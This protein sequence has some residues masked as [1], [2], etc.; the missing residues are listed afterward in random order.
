[1]GA[2]CSG[3][4]LLLWR[5]PLQ[6]HLANFNRALSG[7]LLQWHLANLE[8]GCGAPLEEVSLRYWDQDDVW[9]FAGPH[10]V[11]PGTTALLAALLLLYLLLYYCFTCFFTTGGYERIVQGLSEGLDIRLNSPVTRV[12]CCFTTAASLQLLYYYCF[13]T[14]LL[15]CSHPP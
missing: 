4:S 1:M 8:Y 7:G 15:A 5:G 9:A 2:F 14:A 10:C 3:N 6:W 12:V 13:T 11:C